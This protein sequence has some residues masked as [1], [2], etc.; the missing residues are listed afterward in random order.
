M[1][2]E[3]QTRSN[4]RAGLWNVGSYQVSGVPYLTGSATIDDGIQHQIQFPLVAK[5]VTVINRSA[6]DLRIHFTDK[7]APGSVVTGKH[8]ITLTEDRDSMTF[9]VKCKEIYITSQ[10]DAG[11][12][13][14]FAELTHINTADMY[15][16]TGSGLTEDPTIGL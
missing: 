6:V 4:F 13:E 5:S 8:Y 3:N 14:L 12:Y 7:D 2:R 9:N 16:L 15:T 11:A 10:G 1:A